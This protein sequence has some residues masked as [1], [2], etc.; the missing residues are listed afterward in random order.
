[1]VDLYMPNTTVYLCKNTG[2]DDHNKPFVTANQ[3][4]ATW[5]GKYLFRELHRYSYQ[6]ADER[7]YIAVELNY[8]QCIDVDLILWRNVQFEP[9]RVYFGNVTGIKFVNPECTWIYF[10]LD[11]FLTFCG[12][13][14]WEHSMSLIEREH[15]YQDWNGN[16]PNFENMGL[17]EDFNANLEYRT[18]KADYTLGDMLIAV[19]DPYKTQGE[20]IP[21]FE[22]DIQDNIYS[23]LNVHAFGS[24][25]LVNTYL[26]YVAGS[27]QSSLDNIVDV[28]MVPRQAYNEETITFTY[29]KPWNESEYNNAKC[30]S[31]QFCLIAIESM[32]G[33]TAFFKPELM[34]NNFEFTQEAKFANGNPGILVYPNSYAG[35]GNTKLYAFKITDFPQCAWVGNKYAEWS[36]VHMLATAF[37]IGSGAVG[38]AAGIGGV[39]FNGMDALT[40]P[41]AEAQTIALGNTTRSIGSAARSASSIASDFESIGEA[42]KH[43]TMMGGATQLTNAN[44]AAAFDN[45]NYDV[46]TYMAFPSYMKAID[47]YF[48]MF[49][50]KTMRLGNPV[51]HLRPHWNYV[52]CAK[53]N[54]EGNI[55]FI[56]RIAIEDLLNNGITFWNSSDTIGDYSNPS[57]NKG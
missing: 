41:T 26:K 7:Q 10:Q 35:T 40:S 9:D 51:E 1:M 23:G 42:R 39:Y 52:K 33:E 47:N 25:D 19:R 36:S 17:P 11:P 29:D 4:A 49:G 20:V 54:I 44:I 31:S 3:E 48:T 37:R 43:G 57:S 28:Q 21:D 27:A 56:Y 6:R 45:F 14:N 18:H 8:N 30:F 2:V 15:V 34:N 5:C 38:L 16:D 24:A 55:P 12:D 22:G 32:A 46:A 13:I 50:Y 53:A